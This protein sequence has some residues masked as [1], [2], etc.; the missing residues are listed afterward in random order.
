MS[1]II[2]IASEEQQQAAL[3]T[4]SQII[5]SGGIIAIPTDTV[6]GIAASAWNTAA[7]SRIYQ[8]K[9]RDTNKSIAVLLG[10]ASQAL[11]IAE[12]FSPKATSLAAKFWPGGLTIIVSKKSNLPPNISNNDKIGLRIPDHPFIRDLIRKTGPLATTSAN[13]SGHPAA[14]TVEEFQPILGEQLDLIIDGGTVKGS[15]IA[16]TV[17]DCTLDPIKIL[18]EGSISSEEIDAC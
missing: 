18:R 9:E 12:N 1:K 3:E 10:D 4:A 13:L 16:S 5:L 7:I 17:V 14:K 15:G 8:I 2:Q 11:L 6:Y